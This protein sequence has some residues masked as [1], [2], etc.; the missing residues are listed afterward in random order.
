M[1]ATAKIQLEIFDTPPI[2]L[3]D[4][5]SA[6]L[7]SNRRSLLYQELFDLDLQVFLTGTDI[8]SFKELGNEA[9]YF[10]VEIVSGITICTKLDDITF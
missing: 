7:D 3:L 5:V 9:D 10:R 6:H 4:E 8:N 1:I 2:L